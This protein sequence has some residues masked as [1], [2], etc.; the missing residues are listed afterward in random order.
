MN[1][2][3]C[4]YSKEGRFLVLK[5]I[6]FKSGKL[7]A[8]LTGLQ[9]VNVLFDVVKQMKGGLGTLCKELIAEPTPSGAHEDTDAVCR[10]RYRILDLGVADFKFIRSDGCIYLRI[11]LLLNS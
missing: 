8:S 11:E 9:C 1:K 10:A 6:S 5:K 7:D 4:Y 3:T 2:A